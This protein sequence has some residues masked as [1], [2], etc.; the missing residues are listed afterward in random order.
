MDKKILLAAVS[1]AALLA[2]G[3]FAVA[4]PRE[5]M[6]EAEEQTTAPTVSKE[7]IKE[8]WKDTKKSASNAAGKVSDAAENA[9]ENVKAAFIS[10]DEEVQPVTFNTR[11]SAAGMIGQPVYN[12]RNERVAQVNDIILDRAGNAEIV[13]LSDAGFFKLGKLVAFDYDL[14]SQRSKDGDVIMPLTETTIDR[15]Q[16]F[17]YDPRDAAADTRV[18]PNGGISVAKL[19]D[20]DLLDPN[21]K[22]VAEVDNVTFRDGKAERVIVE[23]DETL[24]MGGKKAALEYENL[25]LV[26][27][28]KDDYNVQLSSR[29]ADRFESYKNQSKKK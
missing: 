12:H 5:N 28:G 25:T 29:Q 7:Q 17:S 3:S 2:S 11:V 4:Q 21:R 24:G 26:S 15:V 8:G 16:K 14:V 10:E 20:A 23:Y 13:I 27:D 9:Y 19:M 6:N 18:M 1:A 22:E